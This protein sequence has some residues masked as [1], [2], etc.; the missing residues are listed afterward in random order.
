MYKQFGII[1]THDVYDYGSSLQVYALQTYIEES[2]LGKIKSI[3]YKPNYLYK[4]VDY[5]CHGAPSQS[6]LFKYVKTLELNEK[7]IVMSLD[8][9]TKVYGWEKL[10]LNAKYE[11]NK[12]INTL[13]S[14]KFFSQFRN[15]SDK[16]FSL[17]VSE[18]LKPS[19]FEVVKEIIVYKLNKIKGYKNEK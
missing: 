5:I 8:F 12:E 7:S 11:S 10:T 13:A 19:I 2:K 9:R 4:L 14:E 18:K 17:L 1:T 15:V 3:D 6:V 16:D